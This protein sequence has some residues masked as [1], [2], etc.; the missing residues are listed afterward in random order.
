MGY[1]LKILFEKSNPSV[2]L[3]LSSR[4]PEKPEPQMLWMKV[5]DKQC[6]S[7]ADVMKPD[8]NQSHDCIF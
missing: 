7:F 2:Q 3:I 6:D 5:S 8:V 4:N 1:M